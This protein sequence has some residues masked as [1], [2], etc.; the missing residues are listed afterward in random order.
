M[1]FFLTA[2]DTLNLLKKIIFIFC[3]TYYGSNILHNYFF[4]FF[5]LLKICSEI[6]AEI[7]SHKA[8]KAIVLKPKK[9]LSF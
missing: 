7:V 5:F 6:Y 9:N 2:N 4:H 1:D 3:N 8:G